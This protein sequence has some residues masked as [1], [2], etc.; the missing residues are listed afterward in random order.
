M[1]VRVF[2]SFLFFFAFWSIFEK[3]KKIFPI[4]FLKSDLGGG[5]GSF[6]PKLLSG[7]AKHPRIC[8][9]F[10]GNVGKIRFSHCPSISTP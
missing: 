1:N 9:C 7:K 4:V 5:G 10:G 6:F 2:L 3:V 8:P